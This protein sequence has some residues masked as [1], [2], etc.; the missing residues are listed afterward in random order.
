MNTVP[1]VANSAHQKKYGTVAAKIGTSH[2]RRLQLGFRTRNGG[3]VLPGGKAYFR[4]EDITR[5]PEAHAHCKWVCCHASCAGKEWSSKGALLADHPDNRELARR[6]E[7]HL[8]YAVADLPEI[9][10]KPEKMDKGRIVEAAV[11]AQHAQVMIL[12]DEE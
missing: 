12:S 7:T 8:Y 11:P 4:I 9:A 6:E 3:A 2:E 1:Y 5:H 10:A